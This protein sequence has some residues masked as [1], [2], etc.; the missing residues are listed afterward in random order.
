MYLPVTVS[1]G[2][3]VGTVEATRNTPAV[4]LTTATMTTITTTTVTTAAVPSIGPKQLVMQPV[5]FITGEAAP[6][7]AA[8]TSMDVTTVQSM[9]KWIQE[10]EA[11]KVQNERKLADL[12]ARVS[13]SEE[14]SAT[15]DTSSDDVQSIST[16]EATPV[17]QKKK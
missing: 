16:L 9:M 14:S 13:A 15:G 17:K 6:W 11:Y 1:S 3:D 5:P 10:L 12:E 8:A 7:N 4:H 2:V